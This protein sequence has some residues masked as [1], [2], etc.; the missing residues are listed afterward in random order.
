MTEL[1]MLYVFF[2]LEQRDAVVDSLLA[3]DDLSGFSIVTL[4]GHSRDNSQFDRLEQVVGYRQLCRVE[5]IVNKLLREQV[6]VQLRQCRSAKT[7]NS[8]FRYY[9]MP[10]LESGHL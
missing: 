10:V 4:D 9:V 5:V 1:E 8:G 7:G 2:P 6:I 3:I